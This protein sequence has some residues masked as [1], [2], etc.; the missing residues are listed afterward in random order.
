MSGF[1]YISTRPGFSLTSVSR[2]GYSTGAPTPAPIS[3]IHTCRK[4]KAA[5]TN[6]PPFCLEL[7]LPQLTQVCAQVCRKGGLGQKQHAGQ[8]RVPPARAPHNAARDTRERKNTRLANPQ[9]G[10]TWGRRGL[11]RNRPASSGR[12]QRAKRER[13][14]RETQTG[15]FFGWGGESTCCPPRESGADTC[16]RLPTQRLPLPPLTFTRCTAKSPWGGGC[17]QT[18][19]PSRL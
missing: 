4:V 6:F 3:L 10:Q 18:A 7:R 19:T 1:G 14:S 2:K 8:V 13:E 12:R 16:P 15:V 11:T 9:P 17:P 5:F